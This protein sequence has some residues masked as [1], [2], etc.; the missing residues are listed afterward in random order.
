V[1]LI[2]KFSIHKMGINAMDILVLDED[3][4]LH[5]QA[6][7]RV[8]LLVTGGDDNSIVVSRLSL[9]SDYLG[10]GPETEDEFVNSVGQRLRAKLDR[11]GH[12]V[13]H[14]SQITG[15]AHPL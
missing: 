3:F 4:D 9:A 14:S 11:L 13:R 15:E 8:E 6:T 7:S 2:D 12:A 5:L 1:E 10:Q